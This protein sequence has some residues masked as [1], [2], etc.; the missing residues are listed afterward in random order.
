SDTGTTRQEYYYP[1]LDTE[2]LLFSLLKQGQWGVHIP[3]RAGSSQ[4]N[5]T[6]SSGRN[7]NKCCDSTC[8]C[9]QFVSC[10]TTCGHPTQKQLTKENSKDENNR[11]TDFVFRSRKSF[12]KPA[13]PASL[14]NNYRNNNNKLLRRA[15]TNT[16]LYSLKMAQSSA[17]LHHNSMSST[18]SL[19][20]DNSSS[21]SSK[22]RRRIVSRLAKK[23]RDECDKILG[24]SETLIIDWRM[25][26]AALKEINRAESRFGVEDTSATAD[27]AKYQDLVMF[28][29]DLFNFTPT[30]CITYTEAKSSEGIS[31]SIDLRRF[32]N[33]KFLEMKKIPPRTVSNL[34]MVK[35]NLF[36]LKCI[37]CIDSIGQVLTDPLMNNDNI[38]TDKK[39]SC[40]WPELK[41]LDLSFNQIEAIDSTAVEAFDLCPRIETLNLSRNRISIIDDKFSRTMNSLS[42]INLTYN[43]LKV[44]PPIPPNVKV[45]I[46]AHNYITSLNNSQNSS[47]HL[48]SFISHAGPYKNLEIL[49]LSSNMIAS[50]TSFRVL[51]EISSLKHLGLNGNPLSYTETYR[52][53]VLSY[54]NK[55]AISRHFSL[56]KRRLSSHEVKYAIE[57]SKKCKYVPQFPSSNPSSS[58][59]SA[60]V[61]MNSSSSR[62]SPISHLTSL[63]QSFDSNSSSLRSS[64]RKK[65]KI[66]EI[67]SI[68]FSENYDENVSPGDDESIV[69]VPMGRPNSSLSG[70]IME[71]STFADDGLEQTRATIK[72]L[73]DKYGADNWL[74]H[75]PGRSEVSK[76][77]CIPEKP[78]SNYLEYNPSR[79][80]PTHGERR[81]GGRR[82][83]C[84]RCEGF[85]NNNNSMSNDNNEKV[86]SDG[87]SVVASHNSSG[88][89]SDMGSSG[90]VYSTN[91]KSK[92]DGH[93]SSSGVTGDDGTNNYSST[94]DHDNINQ[95]RNSIF[96][97]NSDYM[98]E[99]FPEQSENCEY[100]RIFMQGQFHNLICYNGFLFEVD[101][102]DSTIFNKWD[103]NSLISLEEEKCD[104]ETETVEFRLRFNTM[105]KQMREKSFIM[106]AKEFAKFDKLVS[107]FIEKT[108][109]EEFIEALQ[110]TRCHA[111]FSKAM[112]H[113]TV[114]HEK[115]QA[116]REILICP[117]PNCQNEYLVT[118][119]AIP[120]PNNECLEVDR[121]SFDNTGGPLPIRSSTPSSVGK[122]LPRSVPK[123]R[124]PPLIEAIKNIASSFN[125]RRFVTNDM[126]ASAKHNN[127]LEDKSDCVSDAKTTTTTS[128][129]E[130]V[131][132]TRS[133]SDIEVLSYESSS[134]E[135]LNKC[136]DSE[137]DE[138]EVP[139]AEEVPVPEFQGSKN[140]NKGPMS[141]S[142]SSGS[143]A[144]SI[145]TQ[146]ERRMQ[147][148]PISQPFASHAMSLSISTTS[149]TCTSLNSYASN[150]TLTS[151]SLNSPHKSV[152]TT[153]PVR[154]DYVDYGKADH[155]LQLWCELSVFKSANERLLA[156][157]KCL[158]IT[159][160]GNILGIVIF[161]T[162]KIYLYKIT[163]IEGDKP[164]EWLSKLNT[165]DIS[166][167]A[168]LDVLIGR[169]GVGVDLSGKYFAM[170]LRDS[171]RASSFLEF[172]MC[173][174]CC[175]LETPPM[176]RDLS[177]T[178]K[179]LMCPTSPLAYFG[180]VRFAVCDIDYSYPVSA[181]VL[182]QEDVIL[183]T[184]LSWMA[185][186]AS[187]TVIAKHCKQLSA[188]RQIESLENDPTLVRL[189]CDNTKW[190]LLFE[191]ER[192]KESFLST[193]RTDLQIN[194]PSITVCSPIE[195]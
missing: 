147:L 145:V 155:R 129:S 52:N 68:D 23:L 92:Y 66:R 106:C 187:D 20:S 95:T 90:D 88:D 69:R 140:A 97:I 107:P 56:D 83:S 96:D 186:K 33:I 143:C 54:L 104:S 109:M 37:R 110:C 75:H 184:D 163:G 45:L 30:L 74:L 136:G 150:S 14:A 182:T 146:Y 98:D 73:R 189:I 124:S 19:S 114:K 141:E 171:E 21:S 100:F 125:P 29:A 134:I 142:T 82:N 122:I 180:I 160:S 102:Q 5:L 3:P 26:S 139:E 105:R 144:E 193:L 173:E 116:P 131:M 27:D 86:S 85:N 80:L 12:K 25:L 51:R 157:V 161:S 164:Q 103:L 128:S 101:P 181:V 174:I 67:S 148:Q 119:D 192:E 55:M 31:G 87:I 121:G 89:G 93:N 62:P 34:K 11:D 63:T 133:D 166:K 10:C 118:L 46:L 190:E 41:E 120:L 22:T 126:A 18:S 135:V 40:M 169:H 188:L 154:Y 94:A 61:V 132:N 76:I 168:R 38:T 15:L 78:Y 130:T 127:S 59:M 138:V 111:Q 167:F 58:S 49:D 123:G 191:T 9:Q 42:I 43:Q 53:V 170:I 108:T 35:R 28:L 162:A 79:S 194:I 156:I 137:S 99:K 47:R 39:L 183:V 57:Q 159:D 16:S 158:I 153:I 17:L 71:K 149:S 2:S 65:P 32:Q 7:S 84:S 195:P 8:N 48:E 176:V 50:E 112:A 179:A 24:S 185:A 1:V 178:Q 175:A 77:I 6:S 115:G 91:F 152:S 70:S 44:I 13:S 64:R 151:G 177:Q 36:S 81:S 172:F 4:E 117:D 113:K 60:S 165:Y 72:A